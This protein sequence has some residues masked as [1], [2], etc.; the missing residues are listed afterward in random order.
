MYL[1]GSMANKGGDAE[2]HQTEDGK[3]SAPPTYFAF[4][5]PIVVNFQ[6]P[7]GSR[8]LQIT[9]EVMTYDPEVVTAIESHMPVLRNNLLLLLSAQSLESLSTLEGKQEMRADILA[10]IQAVL[11]ERTGKAGV[12]EVYFT[13]FVMQ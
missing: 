10:E 13:T 7:S 11:T 3:P 12:E 9:L 8:Y 2:E 5:P 1:M 4:E 6:D